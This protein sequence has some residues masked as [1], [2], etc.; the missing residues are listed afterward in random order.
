MNASPLASPRPTPKLFV[1]LTL[2]AIVAMAASPG[3][4]A[5][6]ISVRVDASRAPQG[7]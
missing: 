7:V 3:H 4:A 5:P 1:L 2:A 6:P